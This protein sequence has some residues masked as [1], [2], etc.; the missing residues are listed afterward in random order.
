[1][2][3][4]A[5]RCVFRFGIRSAE[6]CRAHEANRRDVCASAA[7]LGGRARP[8]RAVT[9]KR[10]VTEAEAHLWAHAV[11]NVR[12]ARGR[13][14]SVG[15][16]PAPDPSSTLRDGVKARGSKAAAAPLLQPISAQARTSQTV[17]SAVPAKTVSID[18][19]TEQKLKRGRIEIEATLDLH[20]LTQ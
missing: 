17:V 15:A 20:G 14:K 5:R 11:K 8:Q 10:H 1:H 9:R 3:A 13:K 16:A 4:G 18:R 2:R 7:Q 6:N 19:R 12:P